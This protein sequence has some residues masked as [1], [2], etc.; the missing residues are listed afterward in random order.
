MSKNDKKDLSGLSYAE[1]KAELE[2]ATSS[3]DTDEIDLDKATD[4]YVSGMKIISEMEKRLK[5]AKA[6]I[7]K[8]KQDFSA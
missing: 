7:E 6:K 5:D 4:A 8:T 2:S 1:L 3:F